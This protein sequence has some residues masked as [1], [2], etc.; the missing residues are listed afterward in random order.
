MQLTIAVADRVI[1]G[2][3]PGAVPLARRAL[4]LAR[5]TGAP[6]LV[7]TSLLA[8][9]VAVA[10]TDPSQARACLHESRELST[11][12]ATTAPSTW[13]GPRR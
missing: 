11:A 1:I 5:Q 9:G 13:S 2:D 3:I 12:S 4:A 8:M 6:A 10:V 7:A